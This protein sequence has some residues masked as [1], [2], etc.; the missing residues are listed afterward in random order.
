MSSGSLL[1]DEHKL[2][3]HPERVAAFLEGRDVFPLYAEISPAANCNHRCVFCNFNHL[4]HRGLFPAGRMGS[5]MD[6]L[7]RGGVKAVVFAGS[8]EPTLHPETFTAVERAHEAGMDVAMS[9]NGV[10]LDEESIETVVRTLTWI[11]FSLSGGTPEGYARVHR[12]G[13][14][15]FHRVLAVVAKTARRKARISSPLTIGVQYVLLPDNAGDCLTLAAKMK[16]LGADYFVV[17]HFYESPLNPFRIDPSFPSTDLIAELREAAGELSDE[18]FSFVLR[19]RSFTE[20]RRPYSLC[21]GLPLIVYLREDGRVYTCFAHQ[22]DDRTA[23]GSIADQSFGTLWNS[24]ARKKALEYINKSIDK[25]SC[26]AN[27]RHHQVN[28]YL[29]D[30][31]HHPPAHVNFI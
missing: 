24:T 23:L 17:K 8:G 10:L 6:E 11:R 3:Y 21:Y 28:R 13:E 19:D 12:T 16:E 30:L 27:C 15:D 31:R 18:T 25:N 2:P 20:R 4:G 5:L 9:T 26:Q 14:A 1:L 22:D 29:W 7:A